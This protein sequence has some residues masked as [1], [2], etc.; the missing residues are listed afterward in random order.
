MLVMFIFD[1]SR[2]SLDIVIPLRECVLPS[3]QPI[4]NR[5]TCCTSSCPMSRLL[6]GE[7]DVVLLHGGVGHFYEMDVG[8]FA[9]Q[10]LLGIFHPLAPSTALVGYA[11]EE[12]RKLGVF[13]VAVFSTRCLR[14]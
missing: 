1:D 4:S 8:V 10:T 5:P 14:M 3:C 13:P 2:R 7:V 6:S 9:L 12:D 11:P